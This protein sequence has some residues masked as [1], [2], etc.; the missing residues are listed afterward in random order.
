MEPNLALAGGRVFLMHSY[1]ALR[2]PSSGQSVC[3]R[4]RDMHGPVVALPSTQ[5]AAQ[6]FLNF[7]PL[8]QG[9]GSLRPIL[10]AARGAEG[11]AAMAC[12][13]RSMS[14]RSSGWSGSMPTITFQWCFSQ[15]A[16]ISS[17]LGIV[18]TRTT[19]G[20]LSDPSL[21]IQDSPYEYRIQPIGLHQVG[22]SAWSAVSARY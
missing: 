18:C 19:A 7:L 8:P 20:R 12:R 15:R 1:S 3:L 11:F 4:F 21:A 22:Q 9:Q 2:V 10:G 14:E 6:H 16:T 13:R 5:G 17:P